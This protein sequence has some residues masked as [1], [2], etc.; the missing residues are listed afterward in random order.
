MAR[1]TNTKPEETKEAPSALEEVKDDKEQ[2]TPADSAP[3]SD[4]PE[5]VQEDP[6]TDDVQDDKEQ[7]SRVK[8]VPRNGT[9]VNLGGVVVP[10]EGLT[11]DGPHPIL[12][13]FVGVYLSKDFV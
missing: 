9:V 8:Y 12:E 4:P 3:P 6:V 7:P 1:I 2:P 5:V 10:P 13:G 11:H